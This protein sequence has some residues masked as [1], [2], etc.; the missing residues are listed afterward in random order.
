MT[1]RACHHSYTAKA[2]QTYQFCVAVVRKTKSQCLHLMDRDEQISGD[3][4]AGKP[5]HCWNRKCYS[6]QA[7]KFRLNSPLTQSRLP[8]QLQHAAHHSR[9][10]LRY[11]TQCTKC[12]EHVLLTARTQGNSI[13]RLYTT[14]TAVN[15]PVQHGQ[16]ECGQRMGAPLST[17]ACECQVGIG[18]I[19]PRYTTMPHPAGHQRASGWHVTCT[20]CYFPMRSALALWTSLMARLCSHGSS[21]WPVQT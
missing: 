11:T 20:I 10:P 1:R 13:P 3:R 12:P 2:H 8:G 15:P 7:S 17:L 4:V 14:E 9:S 16:R 21:Q 19:R 5:N 6:S 18:T